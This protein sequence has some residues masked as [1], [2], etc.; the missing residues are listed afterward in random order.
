[1]STHT[2]SHLCDLL[3][4]YQPLPCGASLGLGHIHY[5]F[6]ASSIRCCGQAHPR[7]IRWRI[8]KRLFQLVLFGLNTTP[9]VGKPTT[10]RGPG[11]DIF[12]VNKPLQQTGKEAVPNGYQWYCSLKLYE[13]LFM[14][15]G[16]YQLQSFNNSEFECHPCNKCHS[17][18]LFSGGFFSISKS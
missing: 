6:A 16:T 18:S 14:T 7:A 10:P 4:L 13:S 15:T 2:P 3:Q 11:G 8:C 1:M 5:Y 9:G 12:S 17:L